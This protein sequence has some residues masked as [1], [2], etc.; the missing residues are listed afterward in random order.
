ME[1]KKQTRP[2]MKEVAKLSGLSISTVSRHLIDS[3]YVKPETQGKIM[4]AVRQLGYRPN[5]WARRRR[6]VAPR[7]IALVSTMPWQVSGPSSKFNFLMEVASV[8]MPAA[9]TAGCSLVIAPPTEKGDDQCIC[10]MD[11]DGAIVIEPAKDDATMAYLEAHGIPAAVLGLHP[12]NNTSIGVELNTRE[13]IYLLLEHLEE[14]GAG[15]V[16]LLVGKESRNTHIQAEAAYLDFCSQRDIKPVVIKDSDRGGE[17]AGQRMTRQ[18][19]D[20]HPGVDAICI[21][22]DAFALGALKALKSRGIRVPEEMLL[23][24][25]YNS[26]RIIKALPPI[27]AVELNL[28]EAAYTAVEMLL[29]L[30]DKTPQDKVGRVSPPYLI[31]RKSSAGHLRHMAI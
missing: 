21:S 9:L 13:A 1:K 23:A 6:T 19:L 2:T 8:A 5:A 26:P 16:A 22:M 28:K 7:L 11:I 17:D 15:Q 29:K 27:T 31:P 20:F 10:N 12:G 3:G 30:M 14:E 18:L 24:T 4:A 25:R